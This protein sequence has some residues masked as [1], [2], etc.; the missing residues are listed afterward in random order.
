[1]SKDIKINIIV[2]LLTHIFI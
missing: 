2:I 1:L